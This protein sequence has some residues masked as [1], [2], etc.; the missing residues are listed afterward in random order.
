MIKAF[1]ALVVAA[2]A[3][4]VLITPNPEQPQANLQAAVDPPSVAVCP[5]EEGSGRGTTIGIASSIS[6]MGRFTVFAGGGSAGSTD[7]STGASGSAAIPLAE[8]AAVGTAAGLAELPG[9]DVAA[10][11]LLLG[12]ES[13]AVESCLST[14]H[15]QTLLAGGSTISGRQHEVQ[16]MNPYA[17]EALADLIVQ[18]E[19]GLESASQLRGISVPSRSSVV[20]DVGEILPGRESLSFTIE[21]V[22]GSVMAAGR[23][24]AGEDTAV[25]HSVSPALDWYVPIPSGGLGGELVVSTGVG[26]D[27]EYQLDVHGPDGLIEGFQE[28]VVP[29]R[30][31]SVVPLADLELETASAIRV[32]STQPVAVFLRSISEAGV[33]ITSGSTATSSRWFLPG[34]GLAPGSTGSAV[35]LNAGLDE[36]TVVVTA[37]RDQ[38]AAQ[39]LT[40]PAG[41]VIEVPAIEGGANAYSVTGEGLLVPLWVTTTGTDIAYSVGVPLLDE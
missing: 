33:A 5:V 23:F 14:P 35:I 12:T 16:L 40:V 30:G 22:S 10:S 2:L 6:G 11:T 20:V 19:S 41:T 36:A 28:G 39:Q 18:S 15:Q 27:V 9:P 34:A 17:G 31:L 29:G 38:P 26:A 8:V 37:L 4:A 21:V 7:F 32:V 1:F 25:W 13:V 3:A 24:A